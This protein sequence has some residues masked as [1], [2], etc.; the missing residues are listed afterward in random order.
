[1][2]SIRL[3]VPYFLRTRSLDHFRRDLEDIVSVGATYLVLIMTDFDQLF[4]RDTMYSMVQEVKRVGLELQLD[5]WGLAGVICTP[6]SIFPMVHPEA[7]QVASDGSPINRGCPTHPTLLQFVARWIDDA[8]SMGADAVFWDEPQL[9]IWEQGDTVK[10]WSCRCSHCQEAFADRYGTA[11]PTLL[12]DEVIEFRQ[13]VLT[14]LLQTAMGRAKQHGLANSICLLP[15][16]HPRYGFGS[17]EHIASLPELDS[18]GTDPY[19]RASPG[20]AEQLNEFDAYIRHFA[21]KVRRLADAANK[22]PHMWVLGFRIAKGTEGDMERAAQIIWE[23]GIR[24]LAIW[25]DKYGCGDNNRSG[26]PEAVW[27]TVRR[28]FHNWQGQARSTVS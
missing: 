7:C 15:R 26:D 17:W 1:M 9:G 23:A 5:P 19:W 13:D 28:I 22:R 20:N 6:Y 18:F 3:G 11:M 8:A 27:R 25:A 2:T 12:T 16:E 10:R 21:S 24:D 4:F 14:H